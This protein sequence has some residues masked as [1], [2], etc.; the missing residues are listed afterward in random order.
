MLRIPLL[1]QWYALSSPAFKE[2]L[3]EIPPLRRFAQLGGLDNI[4]DENTILTFVACWRPSSRHPA[5]SKL[6]I[7]RSFETY[8]NKKHHW[9]FNTKARVSVD[10]FSGL[11]QP[12]RSTAANVAD[13]K[14]TQA[15]LHGK[16]DSVY[17]ESS[18][19]YTDKRQELQTW[20]AAFFLSPPNAQLFKP[21]TT[22]ACVVGKTA[23]VLVLFALYGWCDVSCCR[24]KDAAA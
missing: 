2:E 5:Q 19:T 4:S 7:E 10:E 1:Q 21:S 20:E 22:N 11:V 3:H 9:Y 17:S 8:Q 24:R 23:Q 6:P 14:V 15:L 12:G 13:F 18:Y 16:E